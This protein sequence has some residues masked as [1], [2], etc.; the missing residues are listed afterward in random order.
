MLSYLSRLPAAIGKTPLLLAVMCFNFLFVGVD[1]L[2]AHSENNVFRWALIPVIFSPVA[3]LAILALLIFRESAVVRRAFTAVMWCG[4]GVGVAGTFFHLTG[5][6]TGGQDTLHS[7][8][9]EGSPIAAPIAF[10]GI[11]VFALAT[12]HYRGPDRR[13]RLLILAGL[14]FACA[15]VAAFLDHG[16]LGFIPVYTLI[17]LVSGTLAAVSCFYLARRRA[18]PAETRIHLYLMALSVV[19]GLVGFGFH[20]AGDL[21]GTESIVWARLLYRNP[22]LGPLLFCDLAL[23]GALSILPEPMAVQEDSPTTGRV[24]EGVLQVT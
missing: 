20:V 11:A 13:S 19:V 4:V 18:N 24:P 22:V 21:A 3:V 7:L 8:M 6:A 17:P 15:V 23:L 1:V 16:R 14:G 2:M 10:A 9:I 5:N 12:E